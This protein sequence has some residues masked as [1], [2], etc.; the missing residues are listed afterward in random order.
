[1]SLVLRV[2]VRPMMLGVVMLDVVMLTVV[3][4]GGKEKKG[5]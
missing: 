5:E 4:P 1:M 3:A 2:S